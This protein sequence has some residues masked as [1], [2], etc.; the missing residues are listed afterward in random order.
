[1]NKSYLFKCLKVLSEERKIFHSED[2]FNHAFAMEIDRTLN[3][4]SKKYSVRLETPIDII[5]KKRGTNLEYN[6]T[7][8]IDMLIVVGNGDWIPIEIKY[9]TKNLDSAFVDH[10]KVEFNPKNHSAN[11]VSRYEIRKDIYRLE[12]LTG[13]QKVKKGFS[14]FLT[15]EPNYWNYDINPSFM[16]G[17]YRLAKRIQK[18]DKGWIYN[19]VEKYYDKKSGRYYSKTNGKLHFTYSAAYDLQLDVKR[20]YEVHWHHYSDVS[21]TEFK[22]TIFEIS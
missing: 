7:A 8:Y 16:D 14:I 10:F 9:K 5:Y 17:H 22:F 1:M 4:E 13:L 2:D 20:D 6:Y 18:K 3:R 11:D 15:N 12:Q 19:S 21:T